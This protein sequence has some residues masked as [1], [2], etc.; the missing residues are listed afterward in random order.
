MRRFV[1]HGGPTPTAIDVCNVMYLFLGMSGV[2]TTGMDVSDELSID[3]AVK[4]SAELLRC[5]TCN[6]TA[7]CRDMYDLSGVTTTVCRLDQAF[8]AVIKY[9]TVSGDVTYARGCQKHCRPNCRRINESYE[10]MQCFSCCSNS[11]CN[12]ERG[13]ASFPNS[14]SNVQLSTI[15]FISMSL[16]HS[17]FR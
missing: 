16:S 2:L 6:Q 7:N 14:L 17:F 1:V 3:P 11:L 8:C 4:V 15:V 9:E 12:S 5:W 10:R 13:S